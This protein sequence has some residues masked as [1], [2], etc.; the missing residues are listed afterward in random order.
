MT[1]KGPR[2]VGIMWDTCSQPR[3]EATCALHP[4]VLNE[5]NGS[6]RTPPRGALCLPKKSGIDVCKQLANP[7]QVALSSPPRNSEVAGTPPVTPTQRAGASFEAFNFQLTLPKELSQTPPGL[8]PNDL[9]A[10][11]QSNCLER[12]QQLLDDDET[13]V[14][15]PLPSLAG[16]E[17]PLFVAIRVGCSASIVSLLLNCGASA[18]DRN[19]VGVTALDLVVGACPTDQI[20]R[21]LDDALFR[22][23]SWPQLPLPMQWTARFSQFDADPASSQ[24]DPKCPLRTET[25]REKQC[26]EYATLLLAHGADPFRPWQG[27]AALDVAK[28]SGKQRLADIMQHAGDRQVHRFL[29]RYWVRADSAL[30]GSSLLR[31]PWD[32]LEHISGFVAPPLPKVTSSSQKI[33]NSCY[34][35]GYPAA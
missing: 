8:R 16:C 32:V 5:S 23:S 33:K 1:H 12:V 3:R 20:P 30:Q 4:L 27:L 15:F 14:H 11:L 17:P 31:C 22:E 25:P 10:A 21:E 9:L 19:P 13:L 34:I 24:G 26:C 35:A 2:D 28:Q 18:T 6:P 7:C 29:C